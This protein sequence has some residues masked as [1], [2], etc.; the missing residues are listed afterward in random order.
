MLQAE[1]NRVEAPPRSTFASRTV[2]PGVSYASFLRGPPQATPSAIPA[3]QNL[4]ENFD[5][6]TAAKTVYILQEVTNI[7]NMIG[8]VDN[9]YTQLK[10]ATS[11]FQKFQV[12]AKC[13]NLSI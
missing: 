2:T 10:T 6:D 12:I 4:L 13:F 7:F 1:I 9:F 8:G 11:P 5:H 3:Q